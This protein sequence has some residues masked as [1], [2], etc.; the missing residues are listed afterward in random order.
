MF[1]FIKYIG[2][3]QYIFDQMRPIETSRYV[4]LLEKAIEESDINM[5]LCLSY[6]FLYSYNTLKRALTKICMDIVPNFNLVRY[7][8]DIQLKFKSIS[9]LDATLKQLQGI[10]IILCCAL[11]SR[12]YMFKMRLVCNEPLL[13]NNDF[14][15]KDDEHTIL[16]KLY[17]H[18]CD[19]INNKQVMSDFLTELT[20]SM[21]LPQ[22]IVK[23]LVKID[24]FACSAM[25]CSNK[26]HQDMWKDSYV[27]IDNVPKELRKFIPNI[28]YKHNCVKDYNADSTIVITGKPNNTIHKIIHHIVNNNLLPRNGKEYMQNVKGKTYDYKM[29]WNFLVEQDVRDT[30]K[31]FRE[32]KGVDFSKESVYVLTPSVKFSDYKLV[33][34]MSEASECEHDALK[35]IVDTDVDVYIRHTDFINNDDHLMR[36][37]YVNDVNDVNDVNEIGEDI[38]E[39]T[40]LGDDVEVVCEGEDADHVY[41]QHMHTNHVSNDVNISV[42]NTCEQHMFEASFLQSS[43]DE[44]SHVQT[45][46][47]ESEPIQARQHVEH[48]CEPI[49]ARQHVPTYT[50]HQ[51]VEHTCEPIQARQHVPT[52]TVHQHVEHTCEPIQAHQHVPTYTVHQ[53]VEHTCESTH[54]E[55]TGKP[56]TQTFQ[57]LS[58]KDSRQFFASFDNITFNFNCCYYSRE[59]A[60]SNRLKQIFLADI[61]NFT[62]D[63]KR[64]SLPLY[65]QHRVDKKHKI[66]FDT[67]TKSLVNAYSK[68]KIKKMQQKYPKAPYHYSD[69]VQFEQL[70]VSNPYAQCEFAHNAK[71]Y[72]I[73]KSCIPPISSESLTFDEQTH[74]FAPYKQYSYRLRPTKILSLCI[75]EIHQLLS[76]LIYRFMIGVITYG[77]NLIHLRSIVRCYDRQKLKQSMSEHTDEPEL[78]QTDPEPCASKSNIGKVKKNVIQ[79]FKVP[80]EKHVTIGRLYSVGDPVM[81]QKQRHVNTFFAMY[82]RNTTAESK[83]KQSQMLGFFRNIVFQHWNYIDSQIKKFQHILKNI[84]FLTD[85]EKLFMNVQLDE[86]DSRR[87]WLM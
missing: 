33:P 85:S 56:H 49:Q 80:G 45:D 24:P 41:E 64:A 23:K 12:E 84:T 55:H 17:F 81:L 79:Q 62:E 75:D 19:S 66:I 8:N 83:Q 34:R 13:T 52:Y 30:L 10:I 86:L 68:R 51:H 39:S 36:M 76:I 27:K 73:T 60:L 22:T 54:V 42:N 72:I 4:P 78:L 15:P 21:R 50:V 61:Y 7:I 20:K 6:G 1:T 37:I 74:M 71:E 3:Q 32:L 57:L 40:L 48:T 47:I 28:D 35:L 77:E 87:R 58:V 26:F 14:D 18:V 65:K 59:Q 70:D 16:R 25:L 5:A 11:K 82:S 2:G 69:L 67:N 53:H 29:F 9:E 63:I 46:H 43:D 31:V 38:G 44:D